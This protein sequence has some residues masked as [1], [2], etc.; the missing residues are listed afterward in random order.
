VADFFGSSIRG[1]HGVFVAL[2]LT[3]I[4]KLGF[5][6]SM[7]PWFTCSEIGDDNNDGR[8]GVPVNVL[9][10]F[11][12]DMASKGFQLCS[13]WDVL[14]SILH[15]RHWL[16]V[17]MHGLAFFWLPLMWSNFLIDAEIFPLLGGLFRCFVSEAVFVLSKD[18]SGLFDGVVWEAP[19]RQ[20]D[21]LHGVGPHSL[22]WLPA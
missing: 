9:G 13:P 1:I 7:V 18:V 12:D 3:M 2:E 10:G 6:P 11:S 14:I 21:L 16:S 22:P 19:L 5:D 20:E 15:S 17:L 8:Y 4:E